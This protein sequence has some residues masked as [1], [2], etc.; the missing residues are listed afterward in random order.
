MK[1]YLS[2]ALAAILLVSLLAG[3][4]LLGGLSMEDLAGTWVTVKEDSQEEATGLLENIEAYEEEIALADLNCLEYVKIVEFHTDESYC[5]RFDVEGTMACVREYYDAYF[6]ALYE[7]RATLEEVYGEDFMSM[8]QAE[9]RQYY[10][11]LYGCTDYIEMLDY[12][13]EIAY[14]YEALE[15]PFETGTFRISGDEILLTITGETKE[16]S[17]GVELEEGTMTLVYIDG[18]ETYTRK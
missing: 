9:F 1:K 16:E 5:F 17:L 6:N 3:C 8:S 2:F 15:E 7:G 4:S 18:Q 14:D 10:A 13:T 12:F 11:A